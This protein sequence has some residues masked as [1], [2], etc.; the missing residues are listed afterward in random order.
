[1]LEFV[2]NEGDSGEVIGEK[3]SLTPMTSAAPTP[4]EPDVS[5]DFVIALSALGDSFESGRELVPF[6]NESPLSL[7]DVPRMGG[8]LDAT[9]RPRIEPLSPF[10]CIREA[11]PAIN[12]ARGSF[13]SDSETGC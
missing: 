2:E 8:G 3:G 4:P 12:I 11:A 9:G 1:M 5:C 7:R 10:S 13:S 6:P